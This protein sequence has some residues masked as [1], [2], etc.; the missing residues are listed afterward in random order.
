[1]MYELRAWTIRN[2]QVEGLPDAV[3]KLIS[4]MLPLRESDLDKICM[5][6]HQAKAEGMDEQTMRNRAY[7][8]WH[9]LTFAVHYPDIVRDALASTYML[10]C[11]CRPDDERLCECCTALAS[12]LQGSVA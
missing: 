5:A 11:E 6:F 9:T 3:A 12:T 1:M 7:Q 8:I 4:E 10:N 2:E